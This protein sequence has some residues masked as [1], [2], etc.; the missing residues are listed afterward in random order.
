MCLKLRLSHGAH[1]PLL[2]SVTVRTILYYAI[3]RATSAVLLCYRCLPFARLAF[4]YTRWEGSPPSESVSS[5]EEVTRA[6]S[7]VSA[8]AIHSCESCKHLCQSLGKL[9]AIDP[10]GQYTTCFGDIV[11]M[12]VREIKSIMIS[13]CD[14][15]SAT[16]RALVRRHRQFARMLEL[17]SHRLLQWAKFK[18]DIP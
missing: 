14:M 10:E 6:A 12:A 1:Y 7:A 5:G 15:T 17:R 2:F 4:L 13:S 18:A 16:R 11:A 8:A 3:G 9:Y